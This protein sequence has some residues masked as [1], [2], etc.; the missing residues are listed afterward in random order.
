MADIGGIMFFCVQV[1]RNLA[2]DI[3]HWSVFETLGAACGRVG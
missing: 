2:N 1:R 3:A